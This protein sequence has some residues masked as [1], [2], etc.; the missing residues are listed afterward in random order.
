MMFC[1]LFQTQCVSEPGLAERMKV[2]PCVAVE[3]ITSGLC[4]SAF[5]EG[6]TPPPSG[7]G[8]SLRDEI[9][10]FFAKDSP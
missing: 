1:F 8:A 9:F 5:S 7:S 10:F 6:L 4:S 3:C 2:H